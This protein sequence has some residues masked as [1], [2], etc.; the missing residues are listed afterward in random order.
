MISLVLVLAFL[1]FSVINASD[2]GPLE[3]CPTPYRFYL[4]STIDVCSDRLS[5]ILPRMGVNKISAFL[6]T[7]FQSY[8][9]YDNDYGALDFV[10]TTGKVCPQVRRLREQQLTIEDG[11]AHN[12][13]ATTS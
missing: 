10:P 8:P 1:V 11:G 9:A 2:L 13:I 4:E 3:S 12:E 6:P 5:F 7:H